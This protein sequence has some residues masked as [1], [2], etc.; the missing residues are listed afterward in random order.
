MNLDGE[1]HFSVNLMNG[2]AFL[3]LHEGGHVSLNLLM[4][5]HASLGL[6]GEDHV[7]MNPLEKGH[8]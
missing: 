1:G 4:S 2:H 5:G 6:H 7:S 3:S 8:V